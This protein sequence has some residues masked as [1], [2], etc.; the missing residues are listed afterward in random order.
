MTVNLQDMF[1]TASPQAFKSMSDSSRAQ[2]L[3]TKQQNPYSHTPESKAKL[4]SAHKGK[5][6]T[7]E[8]IHKMRQAKIG[9]PRSAEAR[10]RT[11][12]TLLANPPRVKPI[13]T[14]WGVF[15]RL[16]DA[17]AHARTQ[18]VKNP[19]NKIIEW[20]RTNPGEFYFVAQKQH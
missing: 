7:P 17:V 10:A 3:A 11:S 5:P 1:D 18:G 12:A 16:H 6:K 8:A 9:K 4:R 15:P 19:R 20:T 14:P 2:M 13:Q